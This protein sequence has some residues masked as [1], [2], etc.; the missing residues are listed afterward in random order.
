MKQGASGRGR[1]LAIA[2]CE[3][4]L[5][6]SRIE[7][8]RLKLLNSAAHKS[9]MLGS[10]G[11]W[12]GLCW[13]VVC[14]LLAA[15][16]SNKSREL[17]EQATLE[18]VRTQQPKLL[19]LLEFL[20]K[21]QP[22][23][24]SQALKEMSRSQARL[25][26]LAKRDPELHAI[27][28]RLWQVRSELRLLAA[29]IAATRQRPSVGEA[30]SSATP[31]ASDQTQAQDRSTSGSTAAG[32]SSRA[33]EQQLSALVKQE[34][35]AELQRLELLRSRAAAELARLDDQ[36]TQLRSNS[37]EQTARQLK[38]WQT[39]INKTSRP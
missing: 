10:L 35:A 13:A 37:E 9:W 3:A 25:E 22:N 18:F 19:K 31:P 17:S 16:A 24:Y 28:L 8:L 32:D 27:E 38:V 14:P 4:V 29:E 26:G 30:A 23:L 11:L 1:W 20:K 5:L 39:R 7:G 2:R 6:M 21:R 33:L 15:D 12:V 36:V 34:L